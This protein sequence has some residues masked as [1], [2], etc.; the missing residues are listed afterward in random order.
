MRTEKPDIADFFSDP[1]RVARLAYLVDVSN[2]L[3][4]LNLSIQGRYASILEVSGK[5]TAFMRKAELW[6]RRLQAGVPDMFPQN[7]CSQTICL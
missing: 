3:N 4:S 7:F 5:L 2:A 1:E 6:R